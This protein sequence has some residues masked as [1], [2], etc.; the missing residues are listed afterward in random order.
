[1][2]LQLITLWILAVSGFCLIAQEED[3]KL[4]D[5]IDVTDE[6][7]IE[8]AVGKSVMI[9]GKVRSS[10]SSPQTADIRIW[11]SDSLFRLFIK[12]DVFDSKDNWRIDESIGKDVFVRGKIVKNGGFTQIE[13]KDPKQ[14]GDNSADVVAA[15]PKTNNPSKDGKQTYEPVSPGAIL[16]IKP[17]TREF[18]PVV[19]EA[20]VKVVL[21]M[22]ATEVPKM[23]ISEV[24]A[25]LIES[26]DSG[27]MQATF[28]SKPKLNTKPMV[29]VMTYLPRKHSGQGWPVN[30]N[31]HFVIDEI[32]ADSAPPNFAAAFL[33][34]CIMRGI[35]V[36]DNL[37]IFGGMDGAGKINYKI[38][39]KRSPGTLGEAIKLAAQAAQAQGVDP[40]EGKPKPQFS[41]PSAL[42]KK[43][44]LA[45]DSFYF[46][47]GEVSDSILDDLIL[48][49]DMMSI[50]S[51]QVI[52]CLNLDEAVNFARDIAQGDGF[53]KSLNDLSAAQKV[54]RERSVRML[55]NAQVWSRVVAAGRATPKNKTAFAYARMKTRKVSKTYSLDKCLAHLDQQIIAARGNA[56]DK[57]NDREMRKYVRDLADK[58]KDIQGK[59]HPKAVPVLSNAQIYL[60]EISDLASEKRDAKANAAQI[61]ERAQKDYDAAKKAYD[62]SKAAALATP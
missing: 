36:P 21:G 1:M 46:I 47:T 62:D 22:H 25:E 33:I 37:V 60:K 8:S 61:S 38:D 51:T 26:E 10:D 18:N 20:S 56:L 2:K 15:N 5:P 42:G 52:S 27:P 12:S 17:G 6:K 14:W 49:N 23:V 41:T 59:I 11:F 43:A 57:F 19:T 40:D 28:E 39:S 35:Q 29:S 7:A 53:G 58:M 44:P 54:M 34:E 48:D 4:S 45:K 30:Q 9:K 16:P 50:N 55:S 31:V 3:E 24:R 32:Q 13:L